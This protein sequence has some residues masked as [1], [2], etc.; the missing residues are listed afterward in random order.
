MTYEKYS[1][2]IVN[3]NIKDKIFHKKIIENAEFVVA[4]D[5]GANILHEMGIIADYLVGDMDSI[6]GFVLDEYKKKNK[7]I[8]FLPEEKDITDSERG[9]SVIRE[10]GHKNVV[11][12]GA[13]GDRIDHFLS[14]LDLFYFAD[15]NGLNMKIMTSTNTVFLVKKGR[16]IIDAEISDIV[17]FNTISGDVHGISLDGFKY[18]LK[19]KDMLQGSFHMTSNIVI[20]KNPII[21]I[22]DGS[23]LCTIVN[24]RG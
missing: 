5:G 19:N 22:K 12:L 11:M 23:L 21:T 17:S 9:I 10:N 3:G 16:T 15:M 14:N 24:N 8:E 6:K 1:V 18:T 7:K 2:I 13:L 4:C 20:K